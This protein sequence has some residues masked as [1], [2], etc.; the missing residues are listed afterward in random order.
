MV[1]LWYSI[2]M[3]E[4]DSDAPPLVLAKVRSKGLAIL[5]AQKFAEVYN[6]DKV[7]ISIV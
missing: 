4:I 6:P 5:V 3:R 2:V 7:T 1:R